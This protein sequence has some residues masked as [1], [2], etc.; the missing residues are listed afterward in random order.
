MARS[1]EK[2]DDVVD[3]IRLED[4]EVVAELENSFKGEQQSK[5]QT[6]RAFS[7]RRK[8]LA[9]SLL[10]F[11]L[12][13]IA[14]AYID[15]LSTGNEIARGV[16]VSGVNV[17]SLSESQAL[18]KLE[19]EIEKAIETPMQFALNDDNVSVSTQ[20]LELSYDAVLSTSNAYQVNRS[21]NPFS[22]IPSFA[23]R[24][25]GGK[26]LE[27]V[28]DYDD[29][30]Y[31][32]V[33]QVIVTALS[34]GRADAGVEIDGT[35]VRVIEPKTGEGVSVNQAETSLNKLIS[36]FDR[37]T[38]EM[39]LED[40][41]A[42]ITLEEANRVADILRTMFSRDS[43]LTT[44]AGNRLE[45]SKE[46]LAS[47]TVVTP[48]K[49]ELV[50]SLDESILREPL[51]EALSNIEIPAKDAT[52]SVNGNSVS[53]VPEVAGKK[54]DFNSALENWIAGKHNFIVSVIDVKPQRDEA[55]ARSLNIT[56]QVSTF[57]TNYPAGQARV[58]NIRRAAEVVNG[59]ILEPGDTFSLNDTLGPRT[60]AAGYVRAPAFS[61]SDGFYDDFG[62]GV[63]QFSTTL[64]NAYYFGGYKNIT[65][66]PHTIYISRYP[67]GREAT[68]NYGSVDLKFQNNSNS[69][70][71]IRTSTTATSVTVTLYGNKEGRK[72]TSEGPNIINEIPY[73]T[74]F[75]DD[76]ALPAGQE[77][78][79]QA[80]YRG[81]TVEN[82]RIIE[83][84]GKE[85]VRERFR[86]TYKMIPRKVARGIQPPPE[87]A[88]V[89]ENV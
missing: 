74:E 22:V 81:I 21:L 11:C 85:T 82:F 69:G 32:A 4:D 49:S 54:V 18:E 1:T 16:S 5:L 12:L 9:L 79:I 72:V 31:D 86:W 53:I 57:T 36:S 28:H 30:K 40:V 80:G 76:P 2:T 58:T 27:V 38:Q 24:I 56:E 73:E 39:T 20:D 60:E 84:P 35:Q 62:G 17:G 10:A 55:W 52:F 89:Q 88:A 15:R 37:T 67:M 41:Q 3:L 70:V 66:K 29:E 64:F 13:F 61:V 33:V 43:V 65:H 59:T 68:L 26:D 47:S 19:G 87:S 44:P 14:I 83:R 6:F 42:Q 25:W 7:N 77:K 71:L 75:I 63:S 78:E 46:L 51:G 48:E 8:Y 45:I 50:I 34:E 23:D